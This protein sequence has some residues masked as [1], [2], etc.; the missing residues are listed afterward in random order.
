MSIIYLLS[1]P[2]GKRRFYYSEALLP[3]SE[4]YLIAPFRCLFPRRKIFF[5]IFIKTAVFFE[6]GSAVFSLSSPLS[7]SVGNDSIF[8]FKICFYICVKACPYFLFILI[9][10]G[11]Y[12]CFF[13]FF[14]CAND[15][16]RANISECIT[17]PATGNFVML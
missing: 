5:C 9:G 15:T 10:K 12:E 3:G 7:V 14:A 16:A 4:R 1:S 8:A 2:T 11:N 17:N 13:I 6:P